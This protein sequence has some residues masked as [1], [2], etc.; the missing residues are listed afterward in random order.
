M[1]NDGMELQ[2]RVAIITGG[3]KGM[4]G[5]IALELARQG[6]RLCLAARDRDALEAEV[7]AI[8]REC[9]DVEAIT[10]SVDVRD[11]EQVKSMAAAALEAFGALDILVNAAGVTGPVETPAHKI[12]L[13][14]WDHILDVNLKGTFLCCKHI[15]PTLIEKKWGKIVNI[16]GTA[17]LRGYVNRAAY[18]S[19]KWA[20][21]GFTRTLA[22]ELGPYNINVNCVCPG[23]TL[24]DRMKKMIRDKAKLW[25]C[26]T[27]EVYDKYTKEMAL[28]RFIEEEEIA[29]AIVYLCSA[30]SR[31]MTGQAL[32][33]D[34]GWDV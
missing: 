31:S 10:V 16:A 12:S 6:A 23:P 4:G 2:G 11:E 13:E 22:L 29:S 9:P 1:T 18:S 15:I 34:G 8:R 5:K 3:A 21:R 32:V 26:S 20:V 30:A 17:S 7:G 33:I 28:G 27:E 24:G 19:S 14:D 25:D